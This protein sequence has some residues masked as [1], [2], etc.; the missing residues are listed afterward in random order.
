MTVPTKT[1]WYLDIKERYENPTGN[2]L[3]FHEYYSYGPFEYNDGD[4][5]SVQ[6]LLD[7]INASFLERH[8]DGA[9]LY[10]ISAQI[11]GGYYDNME[12]KNNFA[13]KYEIRCAQALG[14]A[15][16]NI[17]G[18]T[19]ETFQFTFRNGP[20]GFYTPVYPNDDPVPRGIVTIKSDMDT[21]AAVLPYSTHINT[22]LDSPPVPP[23]IRIV[24]FSGVGNRL[25]L[26]LNS[27]TGEFDA[28]PVLIKGSDLEAV[29]NQYV[30]QTNEPISLTQAQEDISNR[31]LKIT[32]KNDDPID[33]YEIF[34]TT[35]KP[36]SYAD[37][38]S[39][40]GAYKAVS[41]RITMD[42]RASGAHL[43][44]NVQPNTKYY[45]CVRAIDVHN[46]FSN[47][48]HVF[49]AELVDNEGQVYLILKTIYFEETIERIE[50]KAG[51]RYIYIE[52]S[53]RNVTYNTSISP[54]QASNQAPSSNI[55]GPDGDADCW[56]KTLKIRVTSK[57]TGK[58]VDLNVTFKNSGVVTP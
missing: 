17:A 55:L 28:T 54:D 38:A 42:K 19:L 36:N 43:V 48:T 46:N 47:P 29:V 24:P 37:F 11:L 40:E 1:N 3:S 9:P 53:L 21:R 51:R 57:K 20:H 45:Y 33:R 52:P 10:E 2:P 7:R 25:L 8:L 56:D 26:L 44:D 23:D 4:V 14:P 22:I 34:R 58:K 15:A 30:A 6:N 50:T 32:Y 13:V 12:P 49:E 5:I 27:S 35:T 31:T 16:V 41:G 39:A 18:G